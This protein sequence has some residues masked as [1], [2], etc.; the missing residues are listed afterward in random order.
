MLVRSRLFAA[1]LAAG[2]SFTSFAPA[3]VVTPTPSTASP[4]VAPPAATP[5]EAK[6]ETIDGIKYR[7][8]RQT[9]QQT[10]P[11]TIMQDQQQTVYTPKVTT[12]NISHQ[13]VYSI[14]ITQYEAVPVLHGRWNPFVEPYYTY[15]TQLVTRY[16]EQ[17]VN[18]QIPVSKA[19]YVTETK[20]V[21]VPVTEYRTAQQ[22]IE[23]RVALTGGETGKTYAAQPATNQPS[24]AQIATNQPATIQPYNSQVYNR[25][26]NT[27]ASQPVTGVYPNAGYPNQVATPLPTYAP[28]QSGYGNGQ[29]TYNSS[30]AYTMPAANVATRPAAP[31][32]YGGQPAY[33]GQVLPTDPPRQGSG[34]SN[35]PNSG[36]GYR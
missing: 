17:V 6:E 22:V 12:E 9:V 24:T 4:A 14:P 16:Q 11:V 33:G 15:E 36:S 28:A 29:P 26:T 5:L 27:I 23:T 19:E 1:A 3:Q 8:T 30:P 10:M 2:C 31:T 34:W 13:Q 18:V 35:L 25:P 20:T 7:I 32:T 21:Q